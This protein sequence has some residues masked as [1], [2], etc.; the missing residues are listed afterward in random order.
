MD[1]RERKMDF[2][3]A[4]RRFPELRRQL[5]AGTISTEEFDAQLRQLMVRDDEGRWWAKSRKT[6][7]W[8]Y[9]D[10]TAWVRDTPP[11]YQ[12]PS[13]TLPAQSTPDP[14]SQPVHGKGLPSSQT[15][16][17]SAPTQGQNGEKQRRGVPRW[18]VLVA[19]GIVGTAALVG[20]GI[21]AIVGFG[22]ETSYDLVK[23]DSGALSVEVPSEWDERVVVD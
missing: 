11:G 15:A 22:S 3:E 19:A 17:G 18:V 10:G 14:R 9:H 23:D 20:I 8:N 2:R 13:P 1:F 12:P 16:L 4:D 6:G 5:D 7:E 21:V